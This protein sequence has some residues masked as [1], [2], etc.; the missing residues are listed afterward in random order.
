LAGR[1][2]SS[3]WLKSGFFTLTERSLSLLFGVLTFVVLARALDQKDYGTWMLYLSVASF[4][5]VARIGFLKNPL[6]LLAQ[7]G[8]ISFAR[9]QTTSLII[10]IGAGL[11]SAGLLFFMRHSISSSWGTT[12]LAGLF[13][14]Y[15]AG[16]LLFSLYSHLDFIQAANLSFR[17]PSLGIIAEKLVFFSGILLYI[18]QDNPPSLTH[19]GYLHLS[20]VA[21]GMLV[22]FFWGR[23]YFLLWRKPDLLLGKKI[24]DYGKYTLGTNLGAV[25]L[26]NIDTW[27]IGWILHPAA[28][29]TYNVAMRVANLFETPTQALAQVL[30]PK[31]IKSIRNEGPS[32]LKRLYEKSVAFIL[33]ASIPFTLA[34]VFFSPEIVSLLA[35]PAYAESADVLVVTVCFGLL[36]PFNKQLG[37]LMDADGKAKINM[38][39]VLR[40]ALT[41]AVLNY[42][43]I[44]CYGVI[45]A[46]FATLIT[47]LLSLLIES[48]YARRHYNTHISGVFTEMKHWLALIKEK[49]IRRS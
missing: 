47:Y 22:S 36:I 40:N 11:L 24:L 3:Y 42:F 39:F 4:I 46:A 31:A 16:F 27:M 6:I 21:G 18:S 20:S 35:G 12:D 30:F 33:L 28:V 5:E 44:S 25:L 45:G 37:I 1:I 9:L 19:L 43:M 13:E 14:I 23:K 34:V 26:R 48:R 32:A 41:N 7:D 8:K 10:N 49:I 15:C 38:L 17:G 29:A 2:I